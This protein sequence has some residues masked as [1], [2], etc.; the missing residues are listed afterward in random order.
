MQFTSA[1]I[2]SWIGMYLWP[3]FRIAAMVGVAPVFGA[4]NVPVRIRVGIAVALTLVIAPVLPQVPQVDPISSVGVLIIVHQVMIGM[5]IG[6]ALR[7]V[8]AAFVLAGQ[9]IGQT[10]GLG[11]AA[12]VDPQNGV[13]VP[14]VGQFYQIMVTLLFLAMNGHLVL[15]E[16]IADSFRTLPVGP[17]GLGMDSLWSLV[18]WGGQVFAGA[19]LV[20]LPAVTAL[21]VVNIAF[22][23]MTRASP[24]LNIFAVGF[25]VTLGIG[26]VVMLVTL[27]VILPQL[28][29]IMSDA[30]TMMQQL[31]AGG[32]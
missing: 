29:H 9:L 4:Q 13:Q 17:K 16:V 11:F 31:V 18:L 26:V 14:V 6:F 19:V 2:S 30:F 5:A 1:E 10:M 12:M 15:I 8:F 32:R 23:V 27:P 22:G 21:L 28:S 3:L 25:P 7:L 20:S 24:Q